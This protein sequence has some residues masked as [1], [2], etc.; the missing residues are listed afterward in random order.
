M[1]TYEIMVIF[2]RDTEDQERDG[3]LGNLEKAVQEAE[4]SITHRDVWGM[5]TFAYNINH[6]DQGF[7]IVMEFTALGELDELNRLLRLAD[8]VVR[9]K[10]L[11]LPDTEVERRTTERGAA[12]AAAEKEPKKEP[13]KEKVKVNTDSEITEPENVPESVTA[14]VQ[15]ISNSENV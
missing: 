5:R 4:G 6:K 13:E 1:R 8:S 12:G 3:V 10:I 7:Y 2:D 11:R 9:Y 15:D 14:A